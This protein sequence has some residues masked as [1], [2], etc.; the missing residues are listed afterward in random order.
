MCGFWCRIVGGDRFAFKT[1]VGA[2]GNGAHRSGLFLR[3]KHVNGDAAMR[4]VVVKSPR[5]LG[6]ILRKLFGIRKEEYID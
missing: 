6:G 3:Q 4:V 2:G 1:R 5:L